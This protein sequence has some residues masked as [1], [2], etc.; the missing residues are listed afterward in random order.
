MRGRDFLTLDDEFRIL[1]KE[2]AQQGY[3][4]EVQ[5]GEYGVLPKSQQVKFPPSR[6]INAFDA[7][8]FYG[9][10]MRGKPHVAFGRSGDF[11]PGGAE[12]DE[13]IKNLYAD[14]LLYPWLVAQDAQHGDLHYSVGAK[15]YAGGDDHQNQTRYFFLYLFYRVAHEVLLGSPMIDAASRSKLYA[16]IAALRQHWLTTPDAVTPY[17]R[18]LVA[19]DQSVVTYMALAKTKTWY[20]DR[21]AFLKSTDLLTEDR[22]V[23]ATAVPLMAKATI[24]KNANKVLSGTV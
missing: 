10:G 6:V 4:L 12:F 9:A 20:A 15:W 18:L 21:N 22:I 24:R 23:L 2:L 11:T 19:A 17:H 16:D 14:D 13:V 8:R 5:T 1:K 7:L 3:F